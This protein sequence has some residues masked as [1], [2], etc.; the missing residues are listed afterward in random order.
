MPAPI[1]GPDE[2]DPNPGSVSLNT[3]TANNPGISFWS[4]FFAAGPGTRTGVAFD[5]SN[6]DAARTWQQQLIQDLQQQAAGNPNSVAQKQ[7]AASY[8]NARAGQ[9]ALGS[10]VRGTGGGAGLRA[11]VQGAGNVQRGFEGDRAMLMLQEKQ[12]A[13]ALLA[14]QLAAMRSQDAAQAQGAA[15]NALGNTS[16]DDALQ[17]FYLGQGLGLGMSEADR[18]VEAARTAAGLSERR[19]AIGDRTFN[20]AVNAGATGLAAASRW[21]GTGNNGG[22]G[23]H[24]THLDDTD[25]T[26]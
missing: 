2:I 7:L 14:Q 20:N 16:L 18:A 15:Q 25:T 8:A 6:A 9:S 11:G 12:A 22:G 5:T 21:F 13:Q 19:N 4:N 23:T 26:H 3:Q 24:S 10:S 17:Q 1:F